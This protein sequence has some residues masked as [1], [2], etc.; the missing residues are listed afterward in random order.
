MKNPQIVRLYRINEL[1]NTF[2]SR[3]LSITELM[4]KIEVGERT[5]KGDLQVLRD[6]YDAPIIWDRVKR[7]YRYSEPFDLDVRLNLSKKDVAALHSALNILQQFNRL[8]IFEDI[9]GAISKIENNVKFRASNDDLKNIIQLERVPYFKGSDLIPVFV[10]AIKK[11]VKVNFSHQ[12]FDSEAPNIHEIVPYILKEHRN[13]WYVV[14]YSLKHQ[15]V[16]VFGLDRIIKESITMSEDEVDVPNFDAENY[17]KYTLGITVYM[18]REPQDVILS[19]DSLS[20]KYFRTQPF[21]SFTENDVLIDNEKEFRVKL[22][23]MIND[24][25][26]REIVQLG[27]VVKVIEPAELVE[28]VKNFLQKALNNY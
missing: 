6:E 12:R 21:I 5:L 24:E 11:K 17:F 28:N 8:E 19:F 15:S 18:N 3:A 20:G 7:G 10:D 23:L 9:S 1:L 22:K 13:R 27:S 2:K 25:L 26:I 16:R 14:G 4:D